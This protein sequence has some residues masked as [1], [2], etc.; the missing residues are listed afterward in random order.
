MSFSRSSEQNSL[1]QN[2]ENMV[3]KKSRTMMQ[4]DFVARETQPFSA[5]VQNCSMRPKELLL[6]DRWHSM[7]T[8]TERQNIAENTVQFFL[9]PWHFFVQTTRAK[10]FPFMH[11]LLQSSK[12]HSRK[13]SPYRSWYLCPGWQLTS[14]SSFHPNPLAN[15]HSYGKCISNSLEISIQSTYTFYTRCDSALMPEGL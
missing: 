13:V 15:T 5:S 6:Q 2:K 4:Y 12:Q 3:A 14:S 7:E 8:G 10:D 9:P 11:S 1:S